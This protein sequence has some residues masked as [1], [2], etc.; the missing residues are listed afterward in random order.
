[1]YN[2]V[3]TH[4][5]LFRDFIRDYREK[6]KRENPGVEGM[7]ADTIY[8]D[9]QALA[10][11][12]SKHPLKQIRRKR[13]FLKKATENSSSPTTPPSAAKRQ[14]PVLPQPALQPES[15]ASLPPN[16]EKQQPPSEAGA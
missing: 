15:L 1:Y 5:T 13:N 14:T 11:E 16:I 3:V 12:W 9:F 8:Q 6:Y 7:A 4:W 2:T 10:T